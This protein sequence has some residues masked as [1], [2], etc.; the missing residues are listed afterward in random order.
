[1][2]LVW[3]NA[4]HIHEVKSVLQSIDHEDTGFDTKAQHLAET[5]LAAEAHVLPED[6]YLDLTSGLASLES[7]AL[8]EPEISIESSL[9]GRRLRSFAFM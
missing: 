6:A 8:L 7:S 2:V 3:K 9:S 5:H 1:M 4:H